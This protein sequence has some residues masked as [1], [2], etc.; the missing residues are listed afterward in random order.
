[1]VYL[2]GAGPGDPALLTLR[3]SELIRLAD[4]VVHDAS[5]KP[6]MLAIAQK[7]AERILAGPDRSPGSE[8]LSRLLVSKAKEG[9]RVVRLLKGDPYLDLE[10]TAEAELVARS[11]VRFEVVPGVPCAVA[12]AARAGIPLVH[13]GHA[14]TLTMFTIGSSNPASVLDWEKFCRTPGTRV[15]SGR[16]DDVTALVNQL[17]AAGVADDIPVA[18]VRSSG[19]RP[20]SLS[21]LLNE[22][23]ELAAATGFAT[24]DAAVIGDVVSLRTHLNWADRLPLSGQRIAVTRSREQSGDLARLLTEHG[25]DVLEVPCIKIEPPAEREPLLEALAGLGCYDWIVFTSV[26]G[27]TSFFDYFF[28]AFEDLRD[29]GGVRI[30]AVGPATAS[31]I[32]ALH[33]KVD[34]VPKQHTASAIAHE[35][36]NM[37]SLENLRILLLRAEVATPDLPT[38]LEN[39]GAI[40]DDVACYRTVAETED[41]NGAAAKLREEG[42]DWITFT[43]GSTVEQCDFRFNLPEL[44]RRFPGLKLASIGPET[45]KALAAL[46]L[47][48]DLE[49]KPHTVEALVAGVERIVRQARRDETGHG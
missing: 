15:V 17:L 10:G 43:S 47:G 7:T 11:G 13:P 45:T 6:E 37:G 16:F 4:V 3:A 5:T 1:M 30:A 18:L 44:K 49:A 33:L 12:A 35:M 2:V 24:A 38:L 32:E 26:N 25:A 39:K 19:G 36:A 41:R 42:A 14:K 9:K 21:G 48:P 20:E 31:R 40:V 29:L 23:R 22:M 46:S 34:L 28:R 8:S 27:V